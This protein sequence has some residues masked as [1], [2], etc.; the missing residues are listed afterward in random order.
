MILDILSDSFIYETN[1]DT[2]ISYAGLVNTP[3][4]SGT[5]SF[6]LN[7][8][9]NINIASVY[10]NLSTTSG[11]MASGFCGEVTDLGYPCCHYSFSDCL[12]QVN[13]SYTDID[14]INYGVTSAPGVVCSGMVCGGTHHLVSEP[15]F[16]FGCSYT[17]LLYFKQLS[18]VE[19]TH[20]NLFFRTEVI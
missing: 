17:N 3:I 11:V 10:V 19:G 8:D 16:L 12:D 14:F 18:H 4:A 15:Y 9:F 7:F 1:S 20:D 5:K 13:P 6:R 2:C